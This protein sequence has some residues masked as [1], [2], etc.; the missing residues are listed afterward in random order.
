MRDNT[1]NDTPREPAA[2]MADIAPFYVMELLGRAKELKARG[3]RIIHMEVGEPNFP[4]PAPIVEAGMRALAENRTRYTPALGIPE[5]RE[6]IAGFYRQRYG[7]DVS[8]HRIAV[9]P[10]VSSALQLVLAALIDPGDDVIIAD[11]GYPC[12]R[13]MIRLLGGNPVDVP[14]GP[15]TAYQLT[16]EL[17]SRHMTPSTAAIILASPSN[18]TGTLVPPDDMAGIREQAGRRNA[19]L[20]VDEIYLGLVYGEKAENGAGMGGVPGGAGVGGADTALALSDNI[21]VVSGFSKYFGMTGWRLGWLV[22]PESFPR[23]I[24]KLAQNLY[25]SAPTIAQ[26]AALAAFAPETLAILEA[27]REEFRRRRDFLLPALRGLGFDI[28][29]TP[30]GAFYLYAGCRRFTDDSL[31]FALE[32]LD[33]TGV[34]ITPGLDFGKNAPRGHVRFA[35]T[36]G[37]EELQSGVER[38]DDYLSR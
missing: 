14:V 33:N 18:P 21:F 7:V 20:L 6:A 30:Q 10:G 12:N 13:N 15:G 37:M 23:E 2:R 31:S 29:V 38:L 32:L 34:A 24:E 17:V 25:L 8:P 28:P 11:P 9:T 5:L 19:A 26:Y 4:T 16:P 35:Y 27:R 22:A 1:P 3:R 36:T